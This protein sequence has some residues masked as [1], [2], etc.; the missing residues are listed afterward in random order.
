M[1][2]LQASDHSGCPHSLTR[3]V[4]ARVLY[5]KAPAELIKIDNLTTVRGAKKFVIQPL[6][7]RVTVWNL[8]ES[9]RF[10]VKFHMQYQ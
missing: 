4:L 8:G 1:G 3:T 6:W 7:C 9:V 2:S 10:V 5:C